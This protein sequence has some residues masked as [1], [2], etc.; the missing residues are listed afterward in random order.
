MPPVCTGLSRPMILQQLIPVGVTFRKANLHVPDQVMS[1]FLIPPT[2]N[3]LHQA[4]EW[5][6]LNVWAIKWW[7]SY[8]S[9]QVT[10][11]NWS[12]KCCEAAAIMIWHSTLTFTSSSTSQLQWVKKGYM[13][14][15][16]QAMQIKPDISHLRVVHVTVAPVSAAPPLACH[17]NLWTDLSMF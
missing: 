1:S 3:S 11:W 5:D 7:S 12:C 13:L 17:L 8:H 2:S 10:S 4:S 9:F 6:N 14:T 15:L 16:A